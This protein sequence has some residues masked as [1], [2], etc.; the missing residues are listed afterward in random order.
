ML[1]ETDREYTTRLLC[2]AK[3]IGPGSEVIEIVE[4]RT[5]GH[6][7]LSNIKRLNV[8]YTDAESGAI[9]QLPVFVKY[10]DGDCAPTFSIFENEILFYE[11]RLAVDAAINIPKC[12]GASGRGSGRGMELILEDLGDDG[13]ITQLNGCSAGDVALAL[14]EIGR[15]HACCLRHADRVPG[16]IRRTPQAHITD[17]CKSILLPYAG[18]WPPLLEK[19][20][21]FLIK[22]MDGIA[23][24]VSGTCPT[25]VHGDFHCQNMQFYPSRGKRSVRFIDFQ[26]LQLGSPMLDVARILATSMHISERK[27]VQSK[28]VDHH[29]M[30]CRSSCSKEWIY[31]DFRRE[32]LAALLW[33]LLTPLAIH[34]NGIVTQGKKWGDRF[35]ILDRCI[36]AIED[37]EALSLRV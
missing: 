19:S 37:W 1:T 32:F 12:F 33:N 2:N 26:C 30:I 5:S 34:V 4:E 27:K 24:I 13:F 25:V 20:A 10:I 14:A 21:I 16:W 11:S 8:V 28:L 22:N 9:S 15:L 31:E 18:P 23:E 7:L 3:A 36:S 17:Y 29:Y 35:P 6:G